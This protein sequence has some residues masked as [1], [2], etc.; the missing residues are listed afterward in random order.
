MPDDEDPKEAVPPAKDGVRSILPPITEL[1]HWQRWRS[2]LF[3]ERDNEGPKV[4][5]DGV[6]SSLPP[7][8]KLKRWQW[9]CLV[10][11]N[12]GSLLIGQGS[13][14]LLL[15]FYYDQGGHS[16]WMATLAQN[17]GFP[18]LF[19]PFI[20]FPSIK[21]PSSESPKIVWLVSFGLG[22]LIASDNLLYSVGLAY[23][24]HSTYSLICATQL[25]FSAVFSFFMN[26]QRFT[27]LIFNSIVVLSLSASL[28]AV[29]DN[30]TKRPGINRTKYSLGVVST[31]AASVFYA[32]L[33]SLTQ[34][35]FQKVIKK[36]TFSVV[37]ELQICTS[38]I[39]SCLSIVGLFVSGEW[40][41]MRVEIF[42]FHDGSLAYVMTLIWAAVAWQVCSVGVV[43]LIFVVSSLFANAISTF[44][45]S[46]MPLAIAIAYDRTVSSTKTI[47]ILMGLWG[48]WT[49]V[50][51][52]ILDGPQV[53]NKPHH[54]KNSS[55]FPV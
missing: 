26:S 34:L 39:A 51:Q 49:Y 50:Y 29:S 40:R 6:P 55:S 45:L 37:F 1:K 13:A 4:G 20:L 14:V 33:L 16:K 28:A 46:L 8:N 22:A 38:I 12:I 27:I 11:L 19:I 30:S 44:S 23:L 36:E 10:F 25:A 2:R 41:I 24:S 35:S 21:E 53:K 43:G 42:S 52:Y 47:A 17:A 15:R 18:I 48:F 5:N 3:L 54:G 7:I 32:L 9:W 31:L